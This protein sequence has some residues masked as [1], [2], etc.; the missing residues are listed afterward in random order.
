MMLD[1]LPLDVLHP[2]CRLIWKEYPTS[3]RAFS[4]TNR[5]CYIAA[6]PF[7]YHDLRIRISGCKQLIQDVTELTEDPL[8]R[9]CF[10]YTRRLKIDGCMPRRVDSDREEVFAEFGER[11]D[12]DDD[13]WG[14]GGFDDYDDLEPEYHPGPICDYR[15]DEPDESARAWA[16]LATMVSKL[17]HLTDLIY[18]CENQ[19]PAC[20]LRVLHIHHATCRLDLRTFRFRSLRDMS[21]DSH[22]L[23]LATSPCL[24]ALS[25][26]YCSR[27]LLD[28][29][30][31]NKE[32]VLRT[33]AGL[34][35]NL[36]KVGMLCCMEGGVTAQH[37]IQPT[38]K[39]FVPDDGTTKLGA[40]TSLFSSE[41]FTKQELETWSR[42]TD[43]SKLRSL[44]IMPTIEAL[45]DAAVNQRFPS[46]ER[47][48][49][50]MPRGE[51]ERSLRSACEMFLDSLNPLS[52]LRIHASIIDASL[53][54][55]IFQ[56][57]G[58]TLRDLA[59]PPR[60]LKD[61]LRMRDSCPFLEILRIQ[62]KRSMS[63]RRE[64]RF[65]EVLGTLPCLRKL[66]LDLDCSLAET[67][68]FSDD[69]VETFDD[70][71]RELFGPTAW[72]RNGHIRNG[73]INAA[74]D[75]ALVRSIWD[76]IA[77]NKPGC[78]LKYLKVISGMGDNPIYPG[79]VGVMDR[80]RQL[81]RS[82]V[83]TSESDNGKVTQLRELGKMKRD[84]AFNATQRRVAYWLKVGGNMAESVSRREPVDRVF[85]RLWPPKTDSRDW[86]D[87]WSSR[88]LQRE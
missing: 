37:Y 62:V 18:A 11:N 4:L 52:T 59:F 82:Y 34:A 81:R 50:K 75:E 63:D 60:T 53:R 7:L 55:R 48:V 36:R 56:Q 22:E 78:S 2:I 41:V 67:E 65:Y 9:Q 27:D 20:L 85:K 57:H 42:H 19:F 28:Q 10:R 6:V 77:T 38:W 33:V 16:P 49:L 68:L 70:F 3:L 26:R 58:A 83:L 5:T 21:T 87:D 72:W 64:T 15:E 46:L 88:P 30:D 80:L 32:A 47:L 84:E 43:F 24:H 13:D 35:P 17:H 29:D 71:D 8:R 44:S 61:I 54:D 66:S 25:V 12:D 69:I 86:R 23:S 39:G 74:V 51:N 14:D 40:L 1:T 45:A 76:I 73:L 79:G 31:F